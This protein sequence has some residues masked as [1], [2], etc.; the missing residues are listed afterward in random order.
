MLLVAVSVSLFHRAALRLPALFSDNL[1]LQRGIEVPVFGQAL[2]NET[3]TV[4]FNNQVKSTKS[5]TD[6]KWMLKLAAMSEANGSSLII[7]TDS[8]S[9]TLQN[10]AVGEV[11]L[12]SGQSN[13]EF[14]ESAASDFSQAL[15]EADPN[16][17]MFT[18]EKAAGDQPVQD[19]RGLWTPA[20]RHTVGSFSAVAWSF[21][22]ELQHALN[23]PIGLI[24]SSWGGTR[25]ESWT[26]REALTS[27]ESLKLL[28]DLYQEEIKDFPTKI[29][30]YKVALKEWAATRSDTG[31]EGFL[32]GWENRVVDPNG[33]NKVNLPGTIDTMEPVEEGRPFDGA[34]WF[35][36][37]FT[38]PNGWSGKALKL[39][40]G[41]IADYDDVYVNGTKVGFTKA[42]T[43]DGS[44]I[45]RNYRIA[46]GI[47]LQGENSIAVRVYA[48]QGAC[49]FTGLPDQM[50]ISQIGTAGGDPIPLSG[51]WLE[52]IERKVDT[53]VLAPH[54]PVGPGH[55]K[56]PG[57]LFNGMI[58]PLIPFGIKGV[59]WYQGESNAD[60]PTLYNTLFPTLIRDWRQK[61]GQGQF[62]FLYVQ[63]PNFHEASDLPTDSDWALIREAQ[64]NVLKLTR[65]GMVTTI[66]L[67]DA[68]TIH[69]KNKR[70][71]GIRLASLALSK[72][73][74]KHVIWSGPAF[75]YMIKSGESIRA[76]FQHTE[77][78]LRTLDG[79]PPVGFAIAGEDRKFY[80][81]NARIEGIS[82]VLSCPEV[83]NPVAVR[84][85]WADNPI[86]NLVN[87]AN[88][89]TTPFRTDSW[90]SIKTQP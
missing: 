87:S 77:D 11:W 53:S 15:T 65:T 9:K 89:P 29:E 71:V 85:A 73:Y 64:A 81:A 60:Q 16:V 54:M 34:A 12:C 33:W 27:N 41:T 63:L 70:D 45:A 68:K 55:P 30:E 76:Y 47:L 37:S 25:A 39:E 1:V 61:W 5:G 62:P 66:D 26:S 74:G 57:S 6:G 69:P 79:K 83:P 35:R 78:G 31:N 13:M 86:I 36:R 51:Q 32:K 4:L 84:Y 14:Q 24:N 19:V 80:W 44:R 42:T 38:L 21:G 90:P 52:R 28:V 75:Q 7:Q 23:V 46:P 67:G 18:V 50:Q 10:V 58:S 72:E 40:L 56:S 8:A 43:V 3:V 59:L 17:R 82:V 22:R 20:T 49:G 48:A 88:L 2:P